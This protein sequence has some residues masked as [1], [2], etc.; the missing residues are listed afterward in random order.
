MTAGLKAEAE[1]PNEQTSAE[2]REH[3][4]PGVGNMQ[5]AS[6]A[7]RGLGDGG[8][9]AW[10]AAGRARYWQGPEW[11]KREPYTQPSA[12]HNLDE[13]AAAVRG[14]TL[15]GPAR[16]K[17][18]NIVVQLYPFC[19][20]GSPRQRAETRLT[21]SASHKD[22][23]AVSKIVQIKCHNCQWPRTPVTSRRTR[24][25]RLALAHQYGK[26]QAA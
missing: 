19:H 13:A 10:R 7:S 3:S 5:P 17:C 26:T 12:N 23:T 6:Q 14:G 8:M 21:A 15:P 20:T 9:C 11:S 1:R 25:N 16:T 24:A 2:V 4:S 22:K 18:S